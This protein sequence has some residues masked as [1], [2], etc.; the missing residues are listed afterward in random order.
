MKNLPL[1]LPLR[2]SWCACAQ[3]S[4][5]GRSQGGFLLSSDWP[6]SIWACAQNITG[7]DWSR[8]CVLKFNSL[9]TQAV[10]YTTYF[11]LG[12]PVDI[13]KCH[14]DENFIFSIEA[15]L[16]H[17]RVA[18]MRR[19]ILFTIFKY[20]FLF[21]RYSSFWNMQISQVMM[22]YTQP[23]FDQTSWKRISRP[24]C[25]RNVSLE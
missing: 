6:I 24:I 25:I 14:Y 19:K 3:V 5:N 4:D 2:L 9:Y 7:P 11:K 10:A 18:C 17:K 13:F 8:S 1:N 21:Q 16:K 20:I 22:S 23:N 12:E 15:I